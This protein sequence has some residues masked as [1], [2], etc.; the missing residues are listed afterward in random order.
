M[1]NPPPPPPPTSDK[2]SSVKTYILIAFI[3]SLI[4][5]IAW[6]IAA[7]WYIIVATVLGVFAIVLLVPGIIFLV[8]FAIGFM[9]FLRIWRMYNAVNAGDVVTLKATSDMMWAVLTLIFNG[10]IPGIMLIIADG[11]IKQL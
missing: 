1:A 4:V 8:L 5:E 2:L 7:I 3:F 9:C 11:P 10:V 6:I